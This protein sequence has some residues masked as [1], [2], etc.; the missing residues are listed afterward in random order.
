MLNCRL[1]RRSVG[2]MVLGG[3]F[4]FTAMGMTVLVVLDKSL[5][6]PEYKYCSEQKENRTRVIMNAATFPSC[7]DISFFPAILL[8]VLF[9][10]R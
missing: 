5:Y 1:D 10:G 4:G 2:L 8:E 9:S 3:C 7:R 6:Q